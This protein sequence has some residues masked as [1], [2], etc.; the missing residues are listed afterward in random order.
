MRKFLFVLIPILIFTSC[1]PILKLVFN[2]RNVKNLDTRLEADSLDKKILNKFDVDYIM[3]YRTNKYVEATGDSSIWSGEMSYFDSSHVLY[4]QHTNYC[5]GTTHRDINAD[6]LIPNIRTEENK[7]TIMIDS[8][9][10]GLE[11]L[12]GKS[13]E[14][15]SIKLKK[16]N[17]VMD[18]NS[19]WRGPEKKKLRAVSRALPKDSTMFILIN[20]D[21]IEEDRLHMYKRYMS[22]D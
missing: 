6:S 9:L 16:Y 18:F 22:K 17:V 2:V 8:D 15:N 12:S 1:Q 19:F 5:P 11:Y 13:F 4:I 3:L 21:Y 20:K 7:D 10:V 14:L